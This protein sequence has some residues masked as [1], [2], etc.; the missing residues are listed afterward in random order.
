MSPNSGGR[1]PLFLV[2]NTL[3]SDTPTEMKPHWCTGSSNRSALL[4]HLSCHSGNDNDPGNK[5]CECYVLGKKFES[6]SS[7]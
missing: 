1:A 7:K 4:R 6:T 3:S 5:R 2:V